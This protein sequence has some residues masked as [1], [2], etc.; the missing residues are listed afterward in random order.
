MGLFFIYFWFGKSR[1]FF[2]VIYFP[3]GVDVWGGMISFLLAVSHGD[4]SLVFICK[5]F[6]LLLPSSI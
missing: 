2:F 6:D 4:T 1:K 5:E 3:R